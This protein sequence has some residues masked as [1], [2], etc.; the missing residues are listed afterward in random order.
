MDKGCELRGGV[1][2]KGKGDEWMNGRRKENRN[3]GSIIGSE[4]EN[5]EVDRTARWTRLA[6]W[7]E[8][9]ETRAKE[10][11]GGREENFYV[12]VL[13]TRTHIKTHIPYHCNAV[14]VES[15]ATPPS[16]AGIVT[17]TWDLL[18]CNKET[19][20]N[21]VPEHHTAHHM[22]TAGHN[23]TTNNIT[24]AASEIKLPNGH[25]EPQVTSKPLQCTT[26]YQDPQV[27]N[28]FWTSTM[29][30]FIGPESTTTPSNY[31]HAFLMTGET[32]SSKRTY[33]FLSVWARKKLPALFIIECTR[34]VCRHCSC[35]SAQ[36]IASAVY[37]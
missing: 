28:A 33:Q 32:L 10:M 26:A 37:Y 19:T 21:Q 13:D 4:E 7:G 11:N 3:R 17:L 16:D 30:E 9:S 18:G 29:A 12:Y 1:G 35:L 27:Q 8:V 20:N 6:N 15:L 5:Q 31:N 34:N 23:N 22:A 14:R 2:G 24:P 36:E 25:E